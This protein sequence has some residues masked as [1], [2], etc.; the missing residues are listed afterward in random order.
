MISPYLTGPQAHIWV[1]ARRQ[2]SYIRCL[3]SRVSEILKPHPAT[4][5]EIMVLKCVLSSFFISSVLVS[6]L[7]AKIF[8]FHTFILFIYFC[9]LCILILKKKLYEHRSDPLIV[10]FWCIIRTELC[11]FSGAKIY[12]GKGIRFIR[13]DS[14]VIRLFHFLYLE[15]NYV[16]IFCF[17]FYYIISFFHWLV[18]RFD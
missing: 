15:F 1:R 12:P 14:Q 9:Y 3:A 6:V 5:S 4:P 13:S 17:K 16:N 7:C 2:Q 11:K 10:C 8:V 18:V